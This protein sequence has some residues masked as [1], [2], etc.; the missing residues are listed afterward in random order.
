MPKLSGND[1][2]NAVKAPSPPAEAP[3]PT[4]GKASV[5]IC[6]LLFFFLQINKKIM[7]SVQLPDRLFLAIKA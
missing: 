5:P 7:N 3:M 1:R 4:M 6:M 2:S